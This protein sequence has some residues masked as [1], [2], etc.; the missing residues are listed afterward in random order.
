MKHIGG[1]SSINVGPN[2]RVNGSSWGDFLL[3]RDTA[4]DVELE[5]DISHALN[6]SCAVCP[7]LCNGRWPIVNCRMPV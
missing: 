7:D 1:C 4:S 6:C 5:G 2:K 3:M